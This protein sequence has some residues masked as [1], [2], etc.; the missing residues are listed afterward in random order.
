MI[1]EAD[2]TGEKT[3]LS[4]KPDN[5]IAPGPAWSPD[6]DLIAFGVIDRAGDP[7]GQCV[8]SAYDLKTT[9]ARRLSVDK[10]DTCY[11]FVWRRDGKGIVFVGTRPG[12]GNT[13]RRDQIYY[14]SVLDGTHRRLSTDVHRNQPESIGITDTNQILHVPFSRSSQIWA[15]DPAGNSK[16]ASVIT[17]GS[18]DG[19]AGLV[20]LPDGRIAF[21][22]RTGENLGA[23]TIDPDGSNRQQFISDPMIIEE[24]RATPDGKYFFYAAS[25]EN[26]SHLFRVDADGANPKQITSG[27]SYETD[28]ALSSDSKWIVYDSVSSS[29]LEVRRL[30]KNSIEGGAPTQISDVNC[31]VPNFSPTGKYI[32]CVWGSK[33]YVVS[34]DDGAVLHTFTALRI[35]FLNI[36]ARFTPDEKA[37]VYISQQKG[38]TNIWVQPLDGG[39]PRHLTDFPNGDVYN[40]AYSPDGSKLYLARGF[41]IRDAILISGL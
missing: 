9:E 6:G 1:A 25:K 29:N 23:W 10:W 28:S 31:A 12:D 34:P 11:R 21:T 5:V 3:L 7:I 18:S 14:L 15:M 19:R 8:I 16:T 27:D 38:T 39:P 22:A 13:I 4:Y 20:I 33:I 30:W 40:F 36:G 32:S 17:K 2:G 37:V 41:Q 26:R 24:L 35:P